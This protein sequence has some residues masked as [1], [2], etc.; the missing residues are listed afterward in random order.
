MITFKFSNGLELKC[1]DE[2]APVLGAID[3]ANNTLRHREMAR[4]IIDQKVNELTKSEKPYVAKLR[5]DIEYVHQV[6]EIKDQIQKNELKDFE[7]EAE[8]TTKSMKSVSKFDGLEHSYTLYYIN[9]VLVSIKADNG[10]RFHGIRLGGS[11]TE[12]TLIDRLN[13]ENAA[14]A[15]FEAVQSEIEQVL[16]S[17]G[18]EKY[19]ADIKYRDT[20]EYNNYMVNFDLGT[21]FDM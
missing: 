21:D 15:R 1:I 2:C 6:N 19:Y 11:V 9:G 20:K 12:Q 10:R 3:Y 14:V 8:L 5:E 17:Y 18:F 4:R 7:V 16:A 13:A